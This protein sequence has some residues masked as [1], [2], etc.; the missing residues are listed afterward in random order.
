[1]ATEKGK[2]STT[3]PGLKSALD[4]ELSKTEKSDS[5]KS[6]TTKTEGPGSTTQ[7]G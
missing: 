3:Q 6:T 4:T 7:P 1:M 5:D 2:V